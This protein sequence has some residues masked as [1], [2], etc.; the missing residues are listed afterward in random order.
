LSA[1][2]LLTGRKVIVKNVYGVEY[3]GEVVVAGERET[4]VFDSRD[5]VHTVEVG[6]ADLVAHVGELPEDWA[7]GPLTEAFR[8]VVRAREW[9]HAD[10]CIPG[11]GHGPLAKDP[12]PSF[13]CVSGVA[14]LTVAKALDAL[15]RNPR[16]AKTARRIF[17][18]AVCT[19]AL[20]SD[21][22]YTCTEDHYRL[23]A[24]SVASLRRFHTQEG[25]Q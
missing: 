8:R 9:L 11:G 1:A 25:T 7:A 17:H 23:H 12:H 18:D 3:V 2:A 13:R 15:D 21:P 20:D 4:V 22:D 19:S 14:P 24:D 16:D 5:T 10:R 6:A